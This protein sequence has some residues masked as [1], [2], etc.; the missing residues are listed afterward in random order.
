MHRITFKVSTLK[1]WYAIMTE[2]RRLYASN[3]RG[4]PR[5]KRRIESYRW[6]LEPVR[7]WFEVPDPAFAT[8]CAVKLAVEPV[9]TTNK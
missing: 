1:Q 7:I 9:E 6:N 2:A 5:A 3:W 4:Q 8:W